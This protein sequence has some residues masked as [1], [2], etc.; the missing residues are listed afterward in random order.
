MDNLAREI[1]KNLEIYTKEVQKDLTKITNKVTREAVT[2]LKNKTPFEQ[3]G[4][5]KEGWARKK[6]GDSYVIYN[7]NKP[8]L[9]H[10]LEYGHVN[11]DGSRTSGKAHIRPVEEQVVAEYQELIEKAIK[12]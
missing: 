12:Q 9:T 4:E 1:A 2:E 7:K 11:R 6:Q 5:Y 8:Q 3:T 10:L